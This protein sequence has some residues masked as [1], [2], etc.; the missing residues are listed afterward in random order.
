MSSTARNSVPYRVGSEFGDQ[1]P[2]I[3]QEMIAVSSSRQF[4][5]EPMD[6][7]DPNITNDLGTSREPHLAD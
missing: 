5:Y 2:Y 1:E 6:S 7:I 4:H 3:I